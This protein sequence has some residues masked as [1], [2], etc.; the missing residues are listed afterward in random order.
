MSQPGYYSGYTDQAYHPTENT[1]SFPALPTSM[2]SSDVPFGIGTSGQGVLGVAAT[3]FGQPGEAK[4]AQMTKTARDREAR[5]KKKQR[6]QAMEPLSVESFLGL[7]VSKPNAE[8]NSDINKETDQTTHEVKQETEPTIVAGQK[9]QISGK[10]EDTS[11]SVIII[12]D[13]A[14]PGDEIADDDTAAES[15]VYHFD[16]D[17]VDDDQMSDVSVSSVHTSDLSSF[18]DD[19][20]QVASPSVEADNLISDNSPI[21]DSQ[22]DKSCSESGQ[23][24]FLVVNLCFTGLMYMFCQLSA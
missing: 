1:S 12:D 15:K 13:P 24:N 5:A 8:H 18:D 17:A 11:E 2:P 19:I 21:K 3:R 9:E 22:V 6:K 20:E 10:V 14:L 23:L 7:S 16:W 4:P